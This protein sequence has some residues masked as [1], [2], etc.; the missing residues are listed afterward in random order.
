MKAFALITVLF[1]VH[2][3]PYL[4]LRILNS[5]GQSCSLF[6]S[7]S[8]SNFTVAP[9]PV[10]ASMNLNCNLVGTFGKDEVVE[11]VII[12]QH[13]KTAWNYRNVT[14]NKAYVKGDIFN[15]SFSVQA[16]SDSG[17][18]EEQ[19][20]VRQNATQNTLSCWQFSYSL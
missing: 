12:G 19:I 17:T 15:F 7:L 2:A 3:S 11:E 4:E 5:M 6:P 9:W 1:I 16:G 13:Y 8:V 18:Y 20:T 14:I 10:T